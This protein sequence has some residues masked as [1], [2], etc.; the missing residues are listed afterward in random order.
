MKHTLITV[1]GQLGSGKS[2]VVNLL[3]QKLGWA[4]YSTG[5][6][7]RQIAEK[8][9]ISTLELNRLAVSDKTIDEQIDAVFKNPP[10]GNSPCVVDSRLAFHFLPESFKVCLKVSPDEAAK[11]VFNANRSNEKYTTQEQ[12]LLYLNQRRKLEQ[13]HFLKN[14]QLDIE[15][16][17]LFD[18]IIDTSNLSPDQICQKIIE[19]L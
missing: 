7:Q 10:W 13:E 3:A 19:K 18:L 2:T 12:A 14:Y 16:D 4:T 8:M 17:D 1:S 5:Q 6:A 11:R 9:G 15:Q